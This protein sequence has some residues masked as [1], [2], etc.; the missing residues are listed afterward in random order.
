[1]MRTKIQ[2]CENHGGLAGQQRNPQGS[3]WLRRGVQLVYVG[4]SL[5]S[6]PSLCQ[7]V[8]V[9]SVHP[10]MTQSSKPSTDEGR[11]LQSSVPSTV[12]RIHAVGRFP[13]TCDCKRTWDWMIWSSASVC[14]PTP[15]SLRVSRGRYIMALRRLETT[16]Q[17]GDLRR[18][19]VYYRR[20]TLRLSL[21]NWNTERYEA[22]GEPTMPSRLKSPSPI[23]PS[24]RA[25]CTSASRSHLRE[26]R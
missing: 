1:M 18:S 5:R 7:G 24:L 25:T 16:E 20:W 26:I 4:S 6:S 22:L 10:L 11:Y 2:I 14:F 23:Y 12:M 8:Q 15:T 3:V 19:S 13:F 9:R 17:C 21:L